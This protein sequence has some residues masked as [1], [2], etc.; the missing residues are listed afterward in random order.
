[1]ASRVSE[2]AWWESVGSSS[3]DKER[4]SESGDAE[5]EID[6]ESLGVDDSDFEEVDSGVIELVLAESVSVGERDLVYVFVKVGPGVT[7]RDDRVPENVSVSD[8]AERV[9]VCGFVSDSGNVKESEGVSDV[10]SD[11]VAVSEEE[12]EVDKVSVFESECDFEKEEEGDSDLDVEIVDV[13]LREAEKDTGS[14]VNVSRGV[15]D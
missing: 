1:M 11:R 7:V 9:S 15:S 13:E 14:R 10:D 3:F 6:R 2:I 5:V 4:D 12:G 8:S